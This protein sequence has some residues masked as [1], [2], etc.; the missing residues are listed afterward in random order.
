MRTLKHLLS[1][2][3]A[4]VFCG[5]LG[6]AAPESP[7]VPTPITLSVN[8]GKV[9]HVMAGG[10]GASWHAIGSTAFWYPRTKF[11][12]RP[13]D[14]R[15]RGSAWGGTPT[16]DYAQAWKDLAGHVRWLGLDFIRVECDMR[17][18]QP[19]RGKFDWDNEEMQML[20][21]ILEI[22]Q[23]NQAEV[24]LT[25]MWQDVDWNVY[26]SQS[27]LTSAP[28]S[29]PDFAAGLG[30]LLEHLVKTK[31][32][33]C[34]RWL[35]LVNEPVRWWGTA[36]ERISLMPAI[37]AVRTQ[38]DRRGLENVAISGP[39]DFSDPQGERLRELFDWDD[40]AVGA[41][42]MHHY[43]REPD[44]AFIPF[45]IKKARERGIPF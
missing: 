24:F 37:Q 25:Q 11:G 16:V 8:G 20:Y 40:P 45:C 44:A 2:P 12:H 7:E 21:R 15:A 43:G 4:A 1:L 41:L 18:Y 29:V 19:E 33:T 36:G 17:M 42:D 5:H 26:P 9:V 32:Y 6:A 10:A 38:L 30:T 22:C 39:D 13:V 3:A 34:I 27:R 14:R 28:K 35:C 31:G 23:E